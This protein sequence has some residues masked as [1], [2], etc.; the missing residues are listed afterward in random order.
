MYSVKAHKMQN[1]IKPD[2]NLYSF[3]DLMVWI[4]VCAHALGPT[5]RSE[6]NLLGVRSLF[7][8]IGLENKA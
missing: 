7:H 1:Y 2:L 3:I 5:W 6:G 4:W 8:Y